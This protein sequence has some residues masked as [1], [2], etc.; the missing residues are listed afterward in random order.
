MPRS[1]HE[2]KNELYDAVVVPETPKGTFQAVLLGAAR[3]IPR[4]AID[5]SGQ[6]PVVTE[7]SD[8]MRHEFHRR[9][10]I[11]MQRGTRWSTGLYLAQY[12]LAN[13]L[14]AVRETEE[15]AR[16]VDAKGEQERKLASFG[17]IRRAVLNVV[18]PIEPVY[19]RAKRQGAIR[20]PEPT[21]SR[22]ITRHFDGHQPDYVPI[23][24]QELLAA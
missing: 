17:V 11:R 8:G 21:A 9:G 5:V 15:V 20:R 16:F 22:F 1:V 12:I 4:Y 18:D 19:E 24:A 6:K 13:G 23:L 3:Y 14:D 2:R 7:L 10:W